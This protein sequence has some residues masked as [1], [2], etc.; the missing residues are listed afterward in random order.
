VVLPELGFSKADSDSFHTSYRPAMPRPASTLRFESK[1]EPADIESRERAWVER[2]R[3]G[4]YAAFDSMFSAYAD[5]LAAFVYG[6]LKSREDAQEVVQDL[7]LWIW[8][9]RDRWEFPGQLRSYLYRAAR[10]RAISRIRHRRVENYFQL[11]SETHASEVPTRR[12][13]VL[14]EAPD[15]LE[16]ADLSACVSRAISELPERARQV[17]LL[18]RQHHMSYA[19]AA[20][21]MQI[22]P[23]TVEN[24]MARAFAGLRAALGDWK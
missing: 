8:E 5:P 4:D 15:R 11:R 12:T 22:S 10:N 13:A 1:P 6:L 21:V 9:H 2:I 19:P 23:K 20:E 17:F 7:F 14:P 16:A 18:I 3:A 24:H